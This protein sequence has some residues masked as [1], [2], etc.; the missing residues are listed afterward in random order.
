MS[1][2]RQNSSCDQCRRSKRKCVIAQADPRALT[3][4]CLNCISLG[5]SCTYNFVTASKLER[6][7]RLAEGTSTAK[8]RNQAQLSLRDAA[9]E[10]QVTHP[11]CTE[12]AR[13]SEF[14]LALTTDFNLEDTGE[15][16][17]FS[18]PDLTALA[19][20]SPRMPGNNHYIPGLWSGSPIQLLNSTITSSL[21][22]NYLDDIY[23]SMMN[24]I[25]SR[26]LAYTCNLYSPNGKYSFD[27]SEDEEV[28]STSPLLE[29]PN[30]SIPF[31]FATLLGPTDPKS[32]KV[33]FIGLARFL[34][35]F[36]H[37]YGN[38]LDTK[39]KRE[40]IETLVAAKSAFALQWLDCGEVN[41]K[42][43]P[44][45]A[46]HANVPRSQSFSGTNAQIFATAWFN[47]RSRILNAS[48]HRSF[49]RI[50]N[51]FL[52][53]IT[54]PPSEAND[55]SRELND[56]LRRGLLEFL[57]LKS[58]V[59]KFCANLSP[60]ST[61]RMLLESSLK[62]FHWFGYVRDTMASTVFDR[63]CVLP[64]APLRRGLLCRSASKP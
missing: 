64:D 46:V 47:G 40:D 62:I 33:T 30:A 8:K 7:R 29:S 1:A 52:F 32:R 34:D 4:I 35:H 25:E 53:H 24:G 42:T 26:Y 63:E 11:E 60:T 61:Y 16:W 54:N 19:D 9:S 45:G 23:K 39:T 49:T 21:W 31:D 18:M 6:K 27:D 22:G 28:E 59:E 15:R 56:Y 41:P 55:V 14:E 37:L 43:S 38:K 5:S 50:Y 58:A 51:I 17:D 20:F 10:E 2:R 44:A 57:T 12:Q 3:Q 48:P 13:S 36:G